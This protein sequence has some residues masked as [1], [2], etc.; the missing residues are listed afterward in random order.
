V[1]TAGVAEKY[2]LKAQAAAD[3]FFNHANAFHGQIT[4]RGRLTLAER[5]AQILYQRILA[6][7]HTAQTGIRL[8]YHQARS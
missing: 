7:G 5:F 1:S 4:F 2:G 6:A 3:G 8:M